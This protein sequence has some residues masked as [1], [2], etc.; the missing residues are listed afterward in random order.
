MKAQKV[1]EQF[2]KY[3][4]RINETDV[5]QD[6]VVG[7][8]FKANV[9]TY[10]DSNTISMQVRFKKNSNKS[11]LLLDSSFNTIKE[12]PLNAFMLLPS[13]NPNFDVDLVPMSFELKQA[14]VKAYPSVKL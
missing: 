13:T 11:L 8:I 6:L 2:N 12:F 10:A 4:N 14:I 3:E 9:K 7:R 5:F 1:L